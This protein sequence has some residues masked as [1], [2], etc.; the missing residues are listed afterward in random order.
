[1]HMVHFLMIPIGWKE[2]RCEENVD[3][4][5]YKGT[6]RISRDRYV[7]DLGTILNPDLTIATSAKD[8][9]TGTHYSNA[10]EKVT[11]IDTVTYTG[12]KK[13]Q[14][15]VMKGTLMDR[16]TGE[17]ILDGEN[18][19]I[20]ASKRFKPKTAEG[21]VEVKFEFAAK[22]LAGKSITIFEECMLDNTVIAVHKDLERCRSDDSFSKIKNF[23]KRR[24]NRYE[25]GKS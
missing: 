19:N 23:C 2:L 13:G 16:K 12:L 4:V 25:D 3:K 6:F 18:R 21:S 8:E 11:I 9:A 20:T 14:E 22:S 24:S 15:Y 7:V 10:D 1:M 17:M 5:L